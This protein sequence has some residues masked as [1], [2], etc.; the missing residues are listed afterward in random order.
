MVFLQLNIASSMAMNL[1]DNILCGSWQADAKNALED[2]ILYNVNG[3]FSLE[4]KEKQEA[5]I[6]INAK[7]TILLNGI[8]IT[9]HPNINFGGNYTLKDSILTW[10]INDD[11]TKFKL[12]DITFPPA[13][14]KALTDTGQRQSVVSKIESNLKEGIVEGFVNNIKG[15]S[16]IITFIDKNTMK[17]S[18]TGNAIYRRKANSK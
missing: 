4:F 5:S 17:L 15:S 10:T 3:T 8:E 1:T 12:E 18:S 6:C 2:S 13:I 9:F 11:V 14:E 16:T 7:M